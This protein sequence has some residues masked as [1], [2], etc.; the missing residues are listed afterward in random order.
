MWNVPAEPLNS[1]QAEGEEAGGRRDLRL[2]N[3]S[4]LPKRTS[5]S[6]DILF[7]PLLPSKSLLPALTGS[8]GRERGRWVS[9]CPF[10]KESFGVSDSVERIKHTRHSLS[11]KRWR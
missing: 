11:T 8:L 1:A 9:D 3:L 10:W 4:P 7:V 5:Q 2:P 6:L